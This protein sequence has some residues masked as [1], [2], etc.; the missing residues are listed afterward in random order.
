MVNF[1]LTRG[2]HGGEINGELYTHEREGEVSGELY[3][4]EREAWR[5]RQ[6][7]DFRLTI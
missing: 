3:T 7:Q 1:I 2:R 5:G 6:V 4:H